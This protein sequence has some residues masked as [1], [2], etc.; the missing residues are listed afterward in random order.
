MLPS[1]YR[2][3]G[4]VINEVLRHETDSIPLPQAKVPGGIEIAPKANRPANIRDA[5]TD[6]PEIDSRFFPPH[7]VSDFARVADGNEPHMILVRFRYTHHQIAWL[8]LATC[9]MNY[10]ERSLLQS[11]A[12]RFRW[13]GK[14]QPK[15]EGIRRSKSRSFAEHEL[16]VSR[17]GVNEVVCCF[18]HRT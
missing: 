15:I 14:P 12:A 10:A 4:D 6:I 2:R 13:E 9:K 11:P 16:D 1:W 5:G 3:C 7:P 17:R 8:S 18:G